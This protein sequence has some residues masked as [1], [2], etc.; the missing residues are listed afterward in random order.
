MIE[1]EERFFP[2]GIITSPNDFDLGDEESAW[3]KIGGVGDPDL[4]QR[5]IAQ[6]AQETGTADIVL[7]GTQTEED[8][9]QE[10]S[11]T[12]GFGPEERRALV[13]NAIAEIK[14]RP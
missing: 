11:A 3:E 8:P 10:A 12:R 1:G 14:K 13:A 7:A 9:V 4:R 5:L 6:R 2:G